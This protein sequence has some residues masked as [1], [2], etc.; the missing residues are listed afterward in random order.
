M[1]PRT[2]GLILF[3]TSLLS[4]LQ[5]TL[6][7]PKSIQQ[8]AQS[9]GN[10]DGYWGPPTGDFDWCEYNYQS[11]Y[12]IAEPWNTVT[13]LIY[14]IF[15]IL[16]IREH[17]IFS[18][19]QLSI[20]FTDF[21]IMCIFLSFMGIGS[22]LFHST[23]WYKMQLLD[24]MG[25]SFMVCQGFIIVYTRNINK[26][27]KDNYYSSTKFYLSAFHACMW[28]F[29]G[30]IM[31]STADE[32]SLAHRIAHTYLS[33]SYAVY[34]VYIFVAGAKAAN[35]ICLLDVKKYAIVDKYYDR[36]FYS[37]VFG[38]L[39]WM[40][41]NWYCEQLHSLPYVPYFQMHALW[42]LGTC[43]GLYYFEKVMICHRMI[44]EYGMNI[45]CRYAS[46]AGI[47]IFVDVKCSTKDRNE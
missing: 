13:A 9:D 28:F 36:C 33:A 2:V 41:D 22:V 37:F 39:C 8:T 27:Q 21:R 10:N 26:S 45:E 34:F 31:F 12:F 40:T 23:L 15:G 24:E 18:K 25:M 7:V 1:R 38:I 17:T 43:I 20:N 46:I 3:T 16:M 5:Y 47:P 14:V 35:E 29:L 44:V 30:I 6:F 4:F 11:F 32:K 19:N 42:H